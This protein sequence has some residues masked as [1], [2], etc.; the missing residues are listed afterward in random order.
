MPKLGKS[1][2]L[3]DYRTVLE[4]SG[5]IE[6]GA[7]ARRRRRRRMLVA[8]IGIGLTLLAAVLTWVLWPPDDTAPPDSYAA[9]AQCRTCGYRATL[10]VGR[11]QVFPLV[12]PKCQERAMAEVWRCQ[13]CARQFTPLTPEE[14]TRCPSCGSRRVGTAI[15]SK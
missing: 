5:E 8:A 13:A 4:T 2:D 6:V 1:V 15:E 3:A 9:V 10:P 7:Y 11:Q 14:Q 12:C